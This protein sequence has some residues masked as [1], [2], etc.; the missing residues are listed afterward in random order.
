M[1]G[2]LSSSG[3]GYWMSVATDLVEWRSDH[4][5]LEFFEIFQ[6]PRTRCRR[7]FTGKF[8]YDQRMAQDLVR[9]EQ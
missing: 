7:G 3:A 4:G 1:F 8:D 5:L 2:A 9:R 6:C